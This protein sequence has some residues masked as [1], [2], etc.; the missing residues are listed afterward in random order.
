MSFLLN[1]FN[2]IYSTRKIKS[3]KP[4]LSIRKYFFNNKN[5]MINIWHTKKSNINI[6]SIS[7]THILYL[8]L[9]PIKHQPSIAQRIQSQPSSIYIYIHLQWNKQTT[10][11]TP[12]EFRNAY[13]FICKQTL[14]CLSLAVIMV[15]ERY[16]PGTFETVN[17]AP[18][19]C[20][21]KYSWGCIKQTNRNV[22]PLP[23]VGDT[24]IGRT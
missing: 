7:A 2:N 3:L 17:C 20:L 13:C 23:S 16:R 11:S 21:L 19:P 22:K 5:S 12:H 1:N 9:A 10:T 8:S 18:V 15:K 24:T 4:D 14:K 6:K